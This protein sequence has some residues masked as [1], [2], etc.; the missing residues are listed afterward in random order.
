MSV[1]VDGLPG[2]TLSVGDM[3]QIGND[4]HRV[5]EPASGPLTA[6]FAI[7][8]HLWPGIGSGAVVTLH[9]PS[10]LMVIEP[11]SLSASA[12]PKTGR[13]SV[14]FSATEARG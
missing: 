5:L 8:P 7:E 6:F 4:L 13:G 9:K 14:S 10:C 2:I 12:D 11:G 3:I 1:R